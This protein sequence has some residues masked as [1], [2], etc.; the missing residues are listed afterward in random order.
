MATLG[1][2]PS[3]STCPD[4][5][6]IKIQPSGDS[7]MSDITIKVLG[8]QLYQ[9]VMLLVRDQSNQIVG[10]FVNYDEDKLAPVACDDEEVSEDSEAV[11]GH[12]NAKIKTFPLEVGWKAG[13][14]MLSQFKVQGM[15]VVRMFYYIYMYV[16]VKNKFI[17]FLIKLPFIDR[18]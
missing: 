13:D 3:K 2:G 6:S 12:M 5:Y 17:C 15:V 9:G 7:T 16:Y 4:C 11:I 1:H 18:L 14:I 10:R 8:T